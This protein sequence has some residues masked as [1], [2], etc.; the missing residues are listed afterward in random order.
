LSD[1]DGLVDF[2]SCGSHLGKGDSDLLSTISKTETERWGGTATFKQTRAMSLRWDSFMKQFPD[3]TVFN[4]ISIDA[5]GY[6]LI[7]LKQMNLR[8]LGCEMICVEWN[9]KDEQE[10]TVIASA[11]GMK[12]IHKNAENLI[13]AL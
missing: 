4:F 5:E 12:L 2:Y 8:E 6:D 9:G 10:Y 1:I 3:G 7:I 13:F 11:A